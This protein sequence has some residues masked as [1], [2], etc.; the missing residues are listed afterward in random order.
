MLQLVILGGAASSCLRWDRAEWFRSRGAWFFRL[1][2]LFVHAES[3]CLLSFAS[4]HFFF[5]LPAFR[6]LE[7]GSSDDFERR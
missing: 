3:L 1:P 7:I 6:G 2:S 4:L 5:T